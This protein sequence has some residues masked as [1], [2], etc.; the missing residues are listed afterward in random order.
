MNNSRAAQGSDTL[1]EDI[2]VVKLPTRRFGYRGNVGD[3]ERLDDGRL[4]LSYTCNYDSPGDSAIVG[5]IM[6][7]ISDDQGRSWGEPFLLVARPRPT[8]EEE[9]YW[10]PSFLRLANGQ[11]LLS[12]I[13]FAG[14][15]PRF[16]H[17]YYRRS[18]DDGATWGDQLIVT[19]HAGTNHVFNDKLMQLP[20]GRILAPCEREIKEEGG[21]HRGY[22]SLVFYSDDDGYSWHQSENV[23]DTLPVEAQEPH[24]VLL[25]DGRLMMFCRT[26]SEY[27]IRSYSDDEGVTWSPGEHV[28]DLKLPSNS[29]A[30]N[31]KRIP[32]T[33]DLLLLRST[34]TKNRLRTPF[35]SAISTD[36]GSTWIHERVIG[37][38]PEDDYGYPSLTF[39]NDMALVSYH[40]RDGIY[41]ARIGIG[42]F[43]EEQGR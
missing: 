22:V 34:D 8:R 12:Y 41:L 16:A 28:R 43:Y 1:F 11:L 38:D 27:I 19:P 23:V 13:Y 39:V 29:S 15:E 31:V 14:S 17:T 33:G 37:A 32:S 40:K 2:R 6:G 26:Y 7:Q 9:A 36:E 5:D 18:T 21:D 25:R 30:L 3:I 4:L 35:V 42:W 10:H 24:V 20:S